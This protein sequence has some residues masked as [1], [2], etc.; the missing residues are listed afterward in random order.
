MDTNPTIIR[1]SRKRNH[2]SKPYSSFYTLTKYPEEKKNA[3]EFIYI[4]WHYKEKR[5]KNGFKKIK[6]N[7]LYTN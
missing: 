2:S 4:L 6:Q 1:N 7:K 3:T 5:T